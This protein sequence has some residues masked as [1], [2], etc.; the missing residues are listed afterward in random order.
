MFVQP[1]SIPTN[2]S[3]DVAARTLYYS[4][5]SH[6]NGF[7]KTPSPLIEDH[8]HALQ[9]GDAPLRRVAASNAVKLNRA[10]P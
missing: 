9:H 7:R 2:L 4:A 3:C 10:M 6:K 1:L 8:T 5:R